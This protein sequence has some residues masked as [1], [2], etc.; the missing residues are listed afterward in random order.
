MPPIALN[1]AAASHEFAD[2]PESWQVGD[3]GRFSREKALFEYQ[4]TALTLAT[5][6]LWL[7][8]EDAGDWESGESEEAKDA[9][10][11]AFVQKN[12]GGDLREFNAPE[13]T[14]RGRTKANPIF[15]ILERGFAAE[16]GAIP[17]WRTANR[18]G[19]WM[20]TGSGKTLVMIKLAEHLERLKKGGEI[21]PHPILILAPGGHPLGQIRRAVDEFNR[22]G[23]MRIDLAHLRDFRG[24]SGLRFNDTARVYYCDAN[25]FSEEQ[26]EAMVDYRAYENGGKW[27]VMLDEAHRGRREDAKRKAMYSLMARDGFLF[28]FSATFTDADDIA[29]AVIRHNLPDFVRAG[30]GKRLRMHNAEFSAFRDANP[31][32]D[33]GEAA[34]KKITLK[35]LAVLALLKRRVL[36][37]RKKSGLGDIFYHLPLM[38]TLVNSVNVERDGNDLFQFF[39][40]LRE[41]ASGDIDAAALKEA[42]N[43]LAREW[44]D[45]K[46]ELFA[47]EHDPPLC[48]PENP[49]KDLTAAAL[50]EAV[51]LG[52]KPGELEYQTGRDG[53]EIAFK[54]KSAD[55]PFGLIRIGDIKNWT[56][57]FLEGMEGVKA[58]AEKPFFSRLDESPMTMLMGSR[59]FFESWDSN[60]PNI[61]NFINIGGRD[62]RIFVPQSVGRGARIEPLPGR[63]RRL[64]RLLPSLQDD[65]RSAAGKVWGE[66]TPLETLFLFATNRAA[67]TAVLKGMNEENAASEF[68]PLGDAFKARARTADEGPLLIPCYKKEEDGEANSF[69]FFASEDSLSRFRRHMA[70]CSDSVLLVRDGFSA[71]QV[72]QIRGAELGKGGSVRASPKNDYADITLMTRRMAAHFA[73]GGLGKAKMRELE[74]GRDGDIVHF[75]RVSAKLTATEMDLL[76]KKIEKVASF[77]EAE[78]RDG[79]LLQR[80]ARG[81]LT[82][83]EYQRERQQLTR[84]DDFH[85]RLK[86]RHCAS[87]YYSPLALAI[88]GQADWIRHVVREESEVQ[89]LQALEKWLE[90]DPK[91]GWDFWMFSKLDESTDSVYIPYHDCSR[92]LRRKFKPDF[93][94]WMRRAEKYRIVFVDPHGAAHSDWLDKAEGWEKLFQGRAF[95]HK[96]ADDIR[97]RL[98]FYTDD[99]ASVPGDKYRNCWIDNPAAIFAD[100]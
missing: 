94:F 12:Y 73:A 9:R 82:P 98:A 7:Y 29:A 10:K 45:P 47:G 37:V 23:G 87:H 15:R 16:N 89:F 54:L 20:A 18:M 13:F 41:L 49:F 17:Y 50:R 1:T 96:D 71:S 27:L 56:K 48:G 66:T 72:A 65:E 53:K 36:E 32:L 74:E 77:P 52:K 86:I 25:H 59:A 14:D 93:I 76:R 70:D 75:R 81:E 95:S 100:D 39:Q 19:F 21:P 43:E 62:A 30:H 80:V 60:R 61:I 6:A 28:N 68:R 84:E 11:R 85:G 83:E 78:K 55:A 42:A 24:D 46:G 58:L 88:D 63:R 90:K 40:T 92:N 79:E 51:F 97:V 57:D 34:K 64:D 22:A 4:R 44:R 91:A 5:R 3:F 67:M 35:S 26:K 99:R 8:Y 33:I 2:L 38:L 31:D 69:P